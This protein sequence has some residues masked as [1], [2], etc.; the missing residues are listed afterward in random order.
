MKSLVSIIAYNLPS[1]PIAVKI[2]LLLLITFSGYSQKLH[3]QMLSSQGTSTRTSGGITVRQTI[4][5]QSPIGNYRNGNIIAGQGF[6][7]SNKMKIKTPPV[8]SIT[9]TT[10]PNPFIDKVNFQFSSPISGTIKI[11]IFDIM[12]RLVYNKEKMPFEN[13]LTIDNLFFAQ[14]EYFVKLTA[15]NYNYTTILLKSK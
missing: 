14:G 5:Q 13:T 15:K 7:Q 3:H 2:I 11:S 4:G 6:L 12:G 10:Y 1:N 8:I 9:T